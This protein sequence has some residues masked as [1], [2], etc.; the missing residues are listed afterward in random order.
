[1]EAVI[2]PLRD[3]AQTVSLACDGSSE[4]A[5]QLRGCSAGFFVAAVAQSPR[6]TGQLY[7]YVRIT[8]AQRRCI[9]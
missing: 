2:S 3:V 9:Q 1:M 4:G 7:K 5:R 6:K 8:S